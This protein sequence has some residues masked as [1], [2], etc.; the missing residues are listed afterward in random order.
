MLSGEDSKREGF[1]V[2]TGWCV[3]ETIKH[4]VHGWSRV[5][6]RKGSKEEDREVWVRSYRNP[7]NSRR[8]LAFIFEFE[9]IG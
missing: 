7:S 2:R 9:A 6:E 3:R 8:T 4:Q 5:K 1:E